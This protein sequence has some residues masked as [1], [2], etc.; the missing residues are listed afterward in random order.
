MIKQSSEMFKNAYKKKGFSLRSLAEEVDKSF[1]TIGLY[2]DGTH[3]I[4]EGLDEE[5]ANLLFDNSEDKMRF[6]NQIAKDRKKFL[7]IADDVKNVKKTF[8]KMKNRYKVVIKPVIAPSKKKAGQIMPVFGDLSA[9]VDVFK[10]SKNDDELILTIDSK[11]G[12]MLFIE[13]VL[14]R[15]SQ[16]DLEDFISKQD[17]YF[18]LGLIE[19]VRKELEKDPLGYLVSKNEGNM[20]LDN[21]VVQ[22]IIVHLDW[23]RKFVDGDYDFLYKTFSIDEKSIDEEFIDKESGVRRKF[24]SK[25]AELE[26]RLST[27]LDFSKGFIVDG[28]FS[29]EEV[30]SIYKTL[31]KKVRKNFK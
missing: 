19:L 14:E 22:M 24:G 18:S 8:T 12:C 31:M 26:F 21:A 7:N 9:Q 15:V 6:L 4:P 3:P 30:E 5:F 11:C 27:S 16:K 29:R 13:G 25:K 28:M 10:L 2:A 17:S 20:F 1:R 23:A